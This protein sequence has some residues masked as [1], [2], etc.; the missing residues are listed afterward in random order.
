MPTTDNRCKEK[1]PWKLHGTKC[2]SKPISLSI[3]IN[4][5]ETLSLQFEDSDWEVKRFPTESLFITVEGEMVF[6]IQKNRHERLM[7]PTTLDI[8]SIVTSFEQEQYQK[9]IHEYYPHFWA[10]VLLGIFF[11]C[12]VGSGG[13]W[14]QIHH[15]KTPYEINSYLHVKVINEEGNPPQEQ[16]FYYTSVKLRLP[17]PLAS[18]DSIYKPPL[19]ALSL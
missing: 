18:G 3:I 5:I 10:W 11:L 6:R 13:Y 9:V 2:P 17:T 12:I 7:E 19:G 14:Y 1:I 4:L 8:D 16:K 15:Q